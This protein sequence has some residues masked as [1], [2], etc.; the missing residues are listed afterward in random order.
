MKKFTFTGFTKA[1]LFF[2]LAS[3]SFAD[4]PTPSPSRAYPEKQATQRKCVQYE[5]TKSITIN[6]PCGTENRCWTEGGIKV[7]ADVPI[8]CPEQRCVERKCTAWE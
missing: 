3:V 2:T 1:L 5:C 4:F 8:N 7:C 6:V